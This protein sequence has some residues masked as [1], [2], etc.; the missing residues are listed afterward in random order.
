M[1]IEVL[2]YTPKGGTVRAWKQDKDGEEGYMV[3]YREGTYPFW[4]P[5]HAFN[6]MFVLEQAKEAIV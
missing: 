6:E 5:T 4:M 3:G 2:R 1:V